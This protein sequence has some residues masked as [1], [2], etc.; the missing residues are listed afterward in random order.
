MFMLNNGGA[1][2]FAFPDTCWTPLG[3]LIAVPLPYPNASDTSL[4]DPETICDNI[5]LVGLPALNVESVLELSQGDDAGVDGGLVSETDMG[6]V[7]FVDGSE[8][9]M[10]N[11]MPSVRVGDPTG[12][13]GEPP[14]IIGM[15]ASPSQIVVA[16]A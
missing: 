3:G 1:M 6:K 5:L 2:A 15:V 10:L 11:A 8:Q 9:V 4:A 13:N 14:N 16:A 12:Q 7:I